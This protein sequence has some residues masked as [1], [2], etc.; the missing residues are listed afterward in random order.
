VPNPRIQKSTTSSRNKTKHLENEEAIDSN[1][2]HGG[3][4]QFFNLYT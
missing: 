2:Q 4:Q 3:S 1:Q